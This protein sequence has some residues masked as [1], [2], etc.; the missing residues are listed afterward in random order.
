MTYRITT[1]RSE[2]DID[3]IHRFLSEDSYWS[4]R[5]PR[6][7]LQRAIDHSVCFGV[8]D[9]HRQVGFARAVTDCATFAYIADVFILPS[10][11][12][13]GLSKMLMQAIKDHPDL[14]G[15]RRWHLITRD[16]HGLYA[17][18]GFEPLSAPERHM[19][20]ANLGV[21]DDKESFPG[22]FVNHSGA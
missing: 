8:F 2:L 9:D 4:A 10:H 16:A 15:L 3:L 20:I 13:R 14:K 12:G 1:D 22:P 21:Y 7:V 11:R 18:F 19:Q 5:I 6:D 17:Q